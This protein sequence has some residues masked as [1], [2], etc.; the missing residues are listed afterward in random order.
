LKRD[1]MLLK[2]R[3]CGGTTMR[4]HESGF[5]LIELMIVCVVMLIIAALAIP[6]IFRTYQNYQL[7]AAGHSVSS[8]LQQARMQAV[9]TNQPVYVNATATVPNMAFITDKPGNAYASGNPDVAISTALS[10]QPPP[11]TSSFST[12]LDTYLNAGATGVAPQVGGTIGFNARGLP[13][14]AGANP[15]VCNLPAGTSGFEWFM[16]SNGGWEA[17]TVSSSGRIK[18]WRMNG[19]TGGVTNWQ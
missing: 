4:R 3:E 2:Y 14:V 10:F 11:T 15:A 19:Q 18:S 9:K 7:D 17:I 12:Q 13:C 1:H 8:L 16:Q 5:S 6:N